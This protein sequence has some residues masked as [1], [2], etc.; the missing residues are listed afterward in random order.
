MNHARSQNIK[1]LLT[2]HSEQSRGIFIIEP[3][4]NIF[5]CLNLTLPVRAHRSRNNILSQD[6]I[7][8][9]S[10]RLGSTEEYEFLCTGSKEIIE[11]PLSQ[12]GIYSKVCL[13]RRLIL[14]IMRLTCQM[15]YCIN[16]RQFIHL[17]PRKSP[18]DPILLRLNNIQSVNRM[19]TFKILHQI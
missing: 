18:N 12:A 2:C 16:L 6:S 19:L 11:Y 15:D 10:S 4:E 17:L 13:S 9:V 8:S 7:N 1:R 5:L 14:S 3:T